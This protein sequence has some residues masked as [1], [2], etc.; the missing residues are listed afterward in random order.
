VLGPVATLIPTEVDPDLRARLTRGMLTFMV[1]DHHGVMVALRGVARA[2]SL[3][4]ALEFIVI[5]GVQVAERRTTARLPICA[6]VRL[7]QVGCADVVETQT[8]DLSLGGAL[9]ASCPGFGSG[10][11][12]DIEL[13]VE[14]GE[15][16]IRCRATIARRTPTHVGVAFSEI[17]D[18]DRIR[19]AGILADYRPADG[20]RAA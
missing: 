16:A 12:V 14:D 8:A 5:D 3:G 18:A 11:H 9:I 20:R 10:L 1:F 15:P 13:F 6:R 17:D 2:P 4:E 19:L 7:T